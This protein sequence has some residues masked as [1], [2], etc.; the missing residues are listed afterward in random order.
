MVSQYTA[1]SFLRL[2]YVLFQKVPKLGFFQILI[3]LAVAFGPFSVGLSKGYTSPALASL[4]AINNATV[5]SNSSTSATPAVAADI[6]ITAQEGSWIASLSLLGALFGGL[7]ASQL[8]KFGR[9]TC[10]L[11]TAVPFSA[12]WGLTVFATSV[13]MIYATA[14]LAGYA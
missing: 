5:S 3:V 7:L 13:Q 12:S 8:L 14:F 10:L 4:M 2:L 11:V 1:Q 9:R 6:H